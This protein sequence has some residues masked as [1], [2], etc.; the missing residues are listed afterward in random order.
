MHTS[1]PP[2]SLVL[3]S[4]LF[5]LK[6]CWV[7]SLMTHIWGTLL[8]YPHPACD[9]NSLYSN[10]R[11]HLRH[12]P[13]L[14]SSC[15]WQY[16]PTWNSCCTNPCM[17]Q[18]IIALEHI[19]FELHLNLVLYS[20]LPEAFYCKGILKQFGFLAGDRRSIRL[21][22][23]SITD[24]LQVRQSSNFMWGNFSETKNTFSETE[25]KPPP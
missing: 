2:E 22:L 11:A 6:A 16:P 20:G 8:L 14:P 7:I 18:Q 10:W 23:V 5:P 19:L 3:T 13:T 24:N 1:I 9:N 4:G 25:V 17:W 15:M 12:P 21:S